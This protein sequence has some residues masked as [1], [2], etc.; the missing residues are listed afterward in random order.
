MTHSQYGYYI[1][2]RSPHGNAD[3]SMQQMASSLLKEE[4][5]IVSQN[6]VKMGTHIDF[7]QKTYEVV[8]SPLNY[9]KKKIEFVI[10]SSTQGELLS[11]CQ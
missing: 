4:N 10:G 6:C 7:V 2:G 8:R 3:A 5:K 1:H 9:L 11:I